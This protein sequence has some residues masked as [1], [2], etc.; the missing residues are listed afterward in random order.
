MQERR[1]SNS[2]F[3]I[4]NLAPNLQILD[5]EKRIRDPPFTWEPLQILFYMGWEMNVAEQE[6]M[7]VEAVC[8][9]HFCHSANLEVLPL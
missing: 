4:P 1:C 3:S 7:S 9:S 5:P 8:D 2:L 6:A